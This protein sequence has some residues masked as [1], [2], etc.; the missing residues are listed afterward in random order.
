MFEKNMGIE[1]LRFVF[2]ITIVLGHSASSFFRGGQMFAAARQ[3]AIGVEFFF[4]LSGVLMAKTCNR[5]LRMAGQEIA[6]HDMGNATI[7]F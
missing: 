6:F 4:I 2:S 7:S 3:G 5:D 1:L